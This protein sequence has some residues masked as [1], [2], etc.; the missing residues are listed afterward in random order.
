[1]LE[2]KRINMPFPNINSAPLDSLYPVIVV[3]LNKKLHLKKFS[4]ELTNVQQ[5]T[6]EFPLSWRYKDH[7]A[8]FQKSS[9]TLVLRTL[10]EPEAAHMTVIKMLSLL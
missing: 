7:G 8:D 5:Y 4:N 6:L 2:N 10:P 9:W 1:M 3:D